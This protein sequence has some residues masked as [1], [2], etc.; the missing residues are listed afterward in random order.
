MEPLGIN[1][2][3]ACFHVLRG[4]VWVLGL[5]Q[6]SGS[7]GLAYISMREF[8]KIT[9]TLFWGHIRRVLLF[10]VLC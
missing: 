10:R 3:Y 5:R 2:S 8:P 6:G 1:R 7:K 9:G 4:R